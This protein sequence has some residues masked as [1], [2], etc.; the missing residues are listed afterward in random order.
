[1]A[2]LA[3][4]VVPGLLQS[5]SE[6]HGNCRQRTFCNDGDNSEADLRTLKAVLKGCQI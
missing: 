1:M 4:L 3:R 2:T 6:Q 5:R